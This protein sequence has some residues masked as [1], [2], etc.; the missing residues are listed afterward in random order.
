MPSPPP[1]YEIR[2][3]PAAVRQLRDHDE[4]SRQ[5]IKT[6]LTEQ[7]IR[8]ASPGSRGS[9]SLKT[10]RGRHDRFFRLRV[11]ELRIVF[12]LLKEERVLLVHGV[13]NRR[14]LDRWLRRR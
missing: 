9:K 3:L 6:A 5:R 7:A 4:E 1:P 8:I 13:V 14:D 2:L 11:G 12:D 10:I